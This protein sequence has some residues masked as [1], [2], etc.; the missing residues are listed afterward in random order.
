MRK[1]VSILVL[2]IVCAIHTSAQDKTVTGKV[3]DEKDGSAI[4]GASVTVKGTSTGTVTDMEGKFSLKV[5]SSAR[6]LIEQL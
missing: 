5:P 6:T 4:V 3:T 1:L 2:L